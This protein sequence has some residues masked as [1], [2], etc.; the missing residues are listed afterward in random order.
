VCLEW[1]FAAG[2]QGHSEAK[3][4]FT[5]STNTRTLVLKR[6]L[7]GYATKTSSG[8]GVHSARKETSSP[9]AI[10]GRAMNASVW[11]IPKPAMAVARCT[12]RARRRDR[13]HFRTPTGR[14]GRG[15]REHRP[16]RDRHSRRHLVGGR[17]A[18][19]APDRVR[20]ARAP[21]HSVCKRRPRILAARPDYRGAVRQ[22]F[23]HR[24][25]RH[26]VH[27]SK[28]AAFDATRQCHRDHTRSPK[29]YRFS[30]PMTRVT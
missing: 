27:R 12:L 17:P 24:R 8:P 4:A 1:H 3:T 22:V 23:R 6:R 5:Q 25:Q 7:G 13:L 10:A 2:I 30:H 18:A 11:T 26:F 29:R 19:H 21:R 28:R 14:A 15:S 9:R 20:S 16:R